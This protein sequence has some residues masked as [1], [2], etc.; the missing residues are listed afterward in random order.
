MCAWNV[1]L[2][3][4][5]GMLHDFLFEVYLN[6]SG[7]TSICDGRH[8]HHCDSRKAHQFISETARR[9]LAV[10]L[11]LFPPCP[12]NSRTGDRSA[13]CPAWQ[14]G[15]SPAWSLKVAVASGSRNTQT[16]NTASTC[17]IPAGFCGRSCVFC[18]QGYHRQSR[19]RLSDCCT[20]LATLLVSREYPKL[21]KEFTG[22][23]GGRF[24]RPGKGRC[25]G[26]LRSL[27]KQ[28]K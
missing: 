11:Q 5:P 23:V 20:A 22:S 26:S 21:S 6:S 14:P 16:G 1:L 13:H 24:T 15:A 25:L 19:N 7:L 9:R 28:R 8:P 10:V 17:R 4:S 3:E 12:H 2:P 18:R 27:P